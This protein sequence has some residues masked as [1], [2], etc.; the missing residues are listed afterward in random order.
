M[1]VKNE[2]H[3][4]KKTLKNICDHIEI[5]TWVICDTGSTDNTIDEIKQFFQEK[6]IQGE[7][8]QDEW[9]SFSH[10]RNLALQR[11]LGKSDYILIFDADD[12]FEGVFK[13]P[14]VL[15]KDSYLMNM[16][17]ESKSLRYQRK[18]LL[19]N[20]AGFY[21]RSVLHEF[22][23]N[24]NPEIT[25]GAIE[26]D[27]YIVSGRQGDRSKQPDKYSKDALILKTAFEQKEDEEL[28]PRYAFY[29]AQSYRDAG[30]ID[31]A[32]HWYKKRIELQN[33]WSDEIYCSYIELGLLL[34]RQEKIDDAISVWLKGVSHDAKRTECWYQLARIHNWNKRYELAYCF[35][36]QGRT[37]VFPQGNRLFVNRD[38]Y[39]YWIIYEWCLNSFKIGMM[40][41]SYEAFKLLIN[42][43][44]NDL[45]KRLESQVLSYRDMILNDKTQSFLELKDKL[46][47]LNIDI[48]I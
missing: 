36:K 15:E 31:Q 30:D 5:D 12:Y 1:I 25:L 3:I 23:D 17:S 43:A 32:I 46:N 11:C 33:G 37:L 19:K 40:D 7:I 34:E 2:A 16:S 8:Y 42:V 41:E 13:L 35:A 27:Y 45:I 21:W 14:Q 9:K 44:P 18:L 10:N 4:I 6:N 28:L 47:S 39:R 22:I 24:A 38:I 20:D 29:C 26:G 48:K